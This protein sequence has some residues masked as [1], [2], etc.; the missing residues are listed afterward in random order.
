MPSPCQQAG[1][2]RGLAAPSGNVFLPS[3]T[4][5]PASASCRGRGRTHLP[6]AGPSSPQNAGCV[7]ACVCVCVYVCVC[8]CARLPLTL[9]SGELRSRS[10]P[11]RR[12]TPKGTPG[13]SGV[14][15]WES[16][17]G[18]RASTCASGHV[19][20][21]ARSPGSAFPSIPHRVGLTQ[22]TSQS[23]GSFQPCPS[24]CRP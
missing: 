22:G 4:T 6:S 19:G 14:P 11:E 2:R 24:L 23:P 16:S 21:Q 12:S 20:C 3:T 7:R 17:G 18:T 9:K 15:A 1:T 5:M 13:N 8:A 10:D